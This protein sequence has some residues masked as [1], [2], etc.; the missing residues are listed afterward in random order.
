MRNYQN[1]FSGVFFT[2]DVCGQEETF[3][4]TFM[5]PAKGDE[6]RPYGC[7]A[8]LRAPCD[9]CRDC[10]GQTAKLGANLENLLVEISAIDA[11]I[12]KI[13]SLMGR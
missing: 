13:K 5:C 12:S 6:F 1:V 2:C 10:A 9:L 8:L 7:E 11:E 3:S 4:T